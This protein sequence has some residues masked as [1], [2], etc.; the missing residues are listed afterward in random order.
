MNPKTLP[1]YELRDELLAVLRTENRLIIEAPTGSGKSTQVPQMLLDSG[2]CKNDIVVLQPRRIAARMLA[3]RVAY[4]RGGETGG[5]VGYQVRFENCISNKT[6][7]RYVTEGILLRQILSDPELRGVSAV[8][9]DEFHERHLY[10]DITLA[11]CLH[12]QKTRPDLK[13]IVMS[14][15]L[16]AAPLRDYLAPCRE[17]KSEGRMFPVEISYAA[18]KIDFDHKPVWEAAADALESAIRS[19][20]EG[21]VLIFMPGAYEISR[22]VEAVRSKSCAK[23]FAVLPLHG[24]LQPRDQDAAV[25]E[26]ERRK[27]VVATNVAETS[28]TI[29][30]I[31]VV[32]DSGLARI[33]RYDPAR[34]I[35]TLFVE[36]ISRASADQRTGRA[37]RTAPGVCHRL[38][39]LQ[40]QST[41]KAQELPEI[42]RHDLAEV[43]LTLKAGGIDDVENFAW[44]EK[45]DPVSLARTLTLLTD[46]G[47]LTPARSESLA[48]P[49]SSD[50]KGGATPLAEPT[51]NSGG[52]L[53][54][55]GKRMVQFP[56]H[57]RY[58]RM[59]LAADEYHCVR[60]ACLIAA[61]TQGKGILERNKG[62]A[63]RGERDD[64]LGEE[65]V[66]D[67]KRLMRAWSFADKNNY[68]TGA[69]RE[70]GI[71][72][73]AARQVKPLYERFLQIAEQQGLKINT[74]APEDEFLQKCI[75]IAFSDQLAK[76]CDKGTL[77]CELVHGRTAELA[78]ES[79]VRDAELLVAAEITEIGQTR[80]QT[81]VLLNLATA[82]QEEW[83]EELFP[84]DFSEVRVPLY[85]TSIK[86]VVVERRRMFRDLAFDTSITHDP[87]P[88]EAA[89]VLAAEV[90]KGN[91]D[92]PGWD[93]EI[94]NWILRVNLLAEWCPDK[95][96]PKIDEAARRT[97]LEELCFGAVC[98]KDLR[99]ATVKAVVRDWL[100]YEQQQ[101]IEK[102]M[103]ERFAMPGGHRARIR[104][105][106]GHK[107]VLSA[108]IQDFFGM[109]KTPTIA[110]GR[111]PL[112]VELLAPNRRP[113]QITE[114]LESFWRTAYP[115]LKPALSRRYPRHEW[116]ENVDATPPSRSN[117]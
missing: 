41:R 31:R 89:A 12:L 114:D 76:R 60:Q 93:E 56:M 106:A 53:T 17:L 103:P 66:S 29:D 49:V 81:G 10:G 88:D 11:R 38:W 3:R 51:H 21:D 59:L 46:L 95:E 2:L 99:E 65:D 75:L 8:I 43:V 80:G 28:I 36:R 111:I 33:A 79:A 40:E 62:K 71:H 113:V 110:F 15:T 83:L 9:F 67:F 115:E 74:A 58:A 27:V 18:K 97:M 117:K 14:A 22:T 105:E 96:I 25:G 19:G 50:T 82:V 57:P 102:Q 48:L 52:R 47:A 68:N 37:G 104:Y 98:R 39:T 16:D 90:L 87:K 26:C 5:E 34:G 6:R 85:D 45:P 32:I 101:W 72:A 78:R 1:I 112:V 7:I 73:A 63:V 23:D 61:L 20:A 54:E 108:M 109:T 69:C 44:L 24:E 64:L 91:L 55:I 4:E 116:R 84:E 13:I 86:R 35:D 70:L 77:R 100:T 30:G 42:L 107:P 94:E 92:I